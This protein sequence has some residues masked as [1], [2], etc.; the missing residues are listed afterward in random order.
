MQTYFPTLSLNPFRIRACVQA[1]LTD[2]SQ[3][4]MS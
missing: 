4:L 1:K 2:I 3:F